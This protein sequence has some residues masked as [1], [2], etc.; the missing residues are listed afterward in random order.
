MTNLLTNID[1]YM[2]RILQF[3]VRRR[4]ILRITRS[5]ILQKNI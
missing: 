3:L 5:R 2:P 1:L 4:I